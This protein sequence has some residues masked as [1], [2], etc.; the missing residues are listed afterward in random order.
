MSVPRSRQTLLTR[1]CAVP[2]SPALY[3]PQRQVLRQ[4]ARDIPA[5]GP[6]KLRNP[7][8]FGRKLA[9]STICFALQASQSMPLC[10]F[11]S[12]LPN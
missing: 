12:K 8:A 7:E 6:R 2:N 11:G 4:A 10:C 5:R 1:R 9:P 3:I